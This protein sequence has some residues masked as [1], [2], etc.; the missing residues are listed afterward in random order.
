[1]IRKSE[2]DSGVDDNEADQL[3]EDAN[4]TNTDNQQDNEDEG[5]IEDL[6]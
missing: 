5:D 6:L 4:D 2:V 3:F 1:M